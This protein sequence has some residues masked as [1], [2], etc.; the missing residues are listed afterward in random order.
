MFNS[1][2]LFTLFAA[3]FSIA[4]A[5]VRSSGLD[6]E[7]PT[8]SQGYNDEDLASVRRL[9]RSQAAGD[10]PLTAAEHLRRANVYMANRDFGEA[11]AHWQA[12]LDHFPSD[13][14]L[15]DA[16]FGMGRAYFQ[17]RRY[18]ESL[19]FFQRL[20]RDYPQIK[21]GREGLYSMAAGL[22]RMGRPA[23]AAEGYRQYISRYPNGERIEMAYLN[24]I[25]GLREAG[26]PDEANDWITLTRQKFPGTST[27]VNALFASLRLDVA[28]GDWQHAVVVA[29]ELRPRVLL[30]GVLTTFAEVAYLRAYSLERGGHT[31]DA[32]N[33]YMAVPDEAG[34]YYGALSTIRLMA[35]AD[36]TQ[37]PAVAARVSRVTREIAEAAPQYRA[38]YREAI[39][40]AA[41][42]RNLDPRLVLA[43]MRQESQFQPRARSPAA[44]RGLL[45][46]TIDAGARYAPRVGVRDLHESDLYMPGTSI[47]IGSEYIAELQRLF[48]N[49][50]EAVAASY[51]GGEDNVARWVKRANQVDPGVFTAEIGFAETKNY[52]FKVMA[53]YRAYRQLFTRDLR[54]R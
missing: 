29:D 35:I 42:A 50:P 49:L 20:T 44:A 30:S 33:A 53:N 36:A 51:N 47:L 32:A 45:Q 10:L 54:P 5:P 48:P 38:P 37:K 19:P 46:L 13:P 43:I 23:D 16:L 31:Q 41:T 24:V 2:M 22:L 17:D 4:S 12:I 52:V 21:N 11:R 6:M 25:D 26:R 9:D 40:R 15:P 3:G 27:D 34:S 8:E 28:G 1:V 14:N 39:V 7:A 18:S